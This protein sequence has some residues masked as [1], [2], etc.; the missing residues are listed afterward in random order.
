LNEPRRIE[1]LTSP[2]PSGQEGERVS[3]FITVV[4]AKNGEPLKDIEVKWDYPD[5][6]IAPTRTNA[7]G[8]AEVE[9]RLSGVR[10]GLLEATVT[11]GYAG[12]EVKNLEFEVIWTS[13]TPISTPTSD[14]WNIHFRPSWNDRKF[15]WN[16]FSLGLVVGTKCTLMLEYRFNPFI[17]DP[18]GFL[19]LEY[20]KGAEGQGLVFDPPLGQ[21]CEMAEGTTSLSW[22][23]ATEQADSGPFEL[24]FKFPDGSTLPNSPVQPGEVINLAQELEI[25]FDNLPVL[26]AED[27]HAYPCHGAQH[28][29]TLRPK[30]NSPL[31]NKPVKLIWGGT[32]AVELGVRVT[33]SMESEQL[34]TPEGATWT[35]DCRDTTINGD[36]SLTL[37]LVEFGVESSP[38]KMSLGHNLVRAEHWHTEHE[39]W[40]EW[41]PYYV[42]HIRATSVY[43]NSVTPGVTVSI[44]G[45]PYSGTTNAQGEYR[46]REAGLKIINR[47]DGSIV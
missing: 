3:A 42:S 7:E 41:T 5:R 14:T 43:L 21:M 33:P 39:Q 13:I 31:L 15:Y 19:A 4:S 20:V 18:D 35:F 17:G 9:F 27:S 2:K 26:F 28:T 44:N 6:T 36:F 34:L 30:P 22:T 45:S 47:Y 40:P 12:W 37:M 1:A 46:H 29:F 32:S 23:V 38:L 16:E 8:I 10:K 25:K 24:Q 11:G